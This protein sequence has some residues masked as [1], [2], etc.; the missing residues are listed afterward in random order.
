MGL[1]WLAFIIGPLSLIGMWFGEHQRA[2]LVK[3]HDSKEIGSHLQLLITTLHSIVSTIRRTY[4]SMEEISKHAL[5]I[6]ITKPWE[7]YFS[8]RFLHMSD[9]RLY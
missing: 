3:T 5:L 6:T 7:V 1:K 4:E 9:C 8:T 2:N